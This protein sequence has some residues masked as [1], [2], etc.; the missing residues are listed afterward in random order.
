MRLSR[1]I[2]LIDIPVRKHPARNNVTQTVHSL[3]CV[4]G[5]FDYRISCAFIYLSE[6]LQHTLMLRT[7]QVALVE[8]DHRRHIIYLACNQESV[9]KR[10]LHLRKVQRDHQKCAVKIGRYDM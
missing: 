8:N 2:F 10:K 1:I 9:Q 3:A 7:I 4:C 6:G 5:N